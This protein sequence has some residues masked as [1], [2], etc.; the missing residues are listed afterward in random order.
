MYKVFFAETADEDIAFWKKSGQ[1]AVMTKISRLLVDVQE[2][3]L[4]GLGKPE[5]LRFNLTGLYS[6]RI[7]AGNRLVYDVDEQAQSVT[8]YSLRGHYRK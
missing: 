5:A 2:H 6:R 8:V 1:K 4:T 7:D 3:P